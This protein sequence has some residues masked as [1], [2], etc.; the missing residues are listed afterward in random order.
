MK[1]IKKQEIFGLGVSEWWD[2]GA[3]IALVKTCEGKCI[4][5]VTAKVSPDFPSGNWTRT[6]SIDVTERVAL[7]AFSKNEELAELVSSGVTLTSDQTS[8]KHLECSP[9]NVDI[10]LGEI[11]RVLLNKSIDL[12]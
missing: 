8:R 3:G 10:V 6:Q 1:K 11:E 7:V 5:H 9:K 2:M 12:T 4:I